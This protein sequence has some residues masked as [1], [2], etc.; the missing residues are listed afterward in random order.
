MNSSPIDS[1]S[2]RA[3][4]AAFHEVT[5]EDCLIENETK[6]GSS[7]A[8]L[9]ERLSRDFNPTCACGLAQQ[10]GRSAFTHL[11]RNTSGLESLAISPTAVRLNG[12]LEPL[13]ELVERLF[14]IPV[15]LVDARDVVCLETSGYCEGHALIPHLETG[16]IQEY[17]HWA[18]GGKLHPVNLSAK[19]PG[20]TV[21]ISKHPLE[22]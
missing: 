7:L 5:G 6:M 11:A 1:L 15:Q 18:C 16:F 13:E 12:G 3:F 10:I 14:N 2:N 9:C 20:W 19:A 4:N 21:Q 17:V 8:A 22:S